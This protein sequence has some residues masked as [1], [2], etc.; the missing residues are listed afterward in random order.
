MAKLYPS[1]LEIPA[2]D[3]ERATAFYRAVFEL[4]ETPTYDDYPPAR[5][6]VLLPSD[7]SARSP[8][9]SLVASPTCAP[10]RDGVLVNFHVGDHAALERAIHAALAH[11]GS[12]ALPVAD[13]GE[14]VRYLVLLDCEG[15]SIALS[16]YE[17]IGDG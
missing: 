3:L 13:I 6:V 5:I 10:S 14:G 9:V 16:S 12:I 17:S 1:W 7:K 2:R 4:E 11:S 15:N 8:G